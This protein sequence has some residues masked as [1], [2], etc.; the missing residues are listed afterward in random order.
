MAYLLYHWVW[1]HVNT[2]FSCHPGVA[3][4]P[5]TPEIRYSPRFA[6]FGAKQLR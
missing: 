2:P 5:A 6:E 3:G 1:N 4:A